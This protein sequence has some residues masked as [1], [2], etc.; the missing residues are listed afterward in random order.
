MSKRRK[1]DWYPTPSSATEALLKEYT[2]SG[3]ILEP[4][5]GDGAMH[6]VLT[7]LG[8]PI[9]TNDIDIKWKADHHLN[10]SS[11]DL[12]AATGPIDWVI[13]NP[14]FKDAFEIL[15]QSYLHAD[16]GVAML[17]R[18]S[19]L[20]PTFKR[21]QWLAENPPT[22]LF[23]LP[24]ISFT[25]DGKTDSCTCAWMIWRKNAPTTIKIITK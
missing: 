11:P 21:Q 24:R 16:I 15:K 12:Y 19:F 5:V 6:K 25:N 4:C 1:N 23:I 22:S 10:A 9:I 18:I 20:E 14:S 7:T 17:L 2:F 8:L 13:T 3:T